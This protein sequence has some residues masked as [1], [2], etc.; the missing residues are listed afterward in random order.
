MYLGDPLIFGLLQAYP[1]TKR[2]SIFVGLILMC[3]SLGLSSLCQT[4][5]Q[6]IGTQG[7]L[8]AIG[9]SLIYSPTILFMDEWFV[10]RKGLAFGVMWVR[11]TLL[12]FFFFYYHRPS[13]ATEL[14]NLVPIS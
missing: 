11:I 12:P 6:L 1:H 2:P 13:K 14:F 7:V 10:Q 3:L 5:P 8:Y 9:G 4:V